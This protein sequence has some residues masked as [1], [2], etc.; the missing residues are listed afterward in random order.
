L[1]ESPAF[2]GLRPVQR[3]R[4]VYR[5]LGD[6]MQERVHALAMETRAPGE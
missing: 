4:L 3:Q 2:A 1:I 5:A 6:L